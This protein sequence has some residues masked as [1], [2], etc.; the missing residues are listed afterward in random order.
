ME[1][2]YIK[3]YSGN[4]MVS[5]RIVE[6]LEQIGIVPIIKDESESARLAGF[7]SP[8]QENQEIY[9]HK[10]ET[11]KAKTI[12]DRILAEIKA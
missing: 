6:A 2:D 10:A 11:E 9:V 7:P 5:S 1:R 4:F 8:M 12:I 3:I